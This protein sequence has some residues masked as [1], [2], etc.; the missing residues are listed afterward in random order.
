VKHDAPN[1]ATKISRI[2][3]DIFVPENQQSDVLTLRFAMH[4][5]P[6]RLGDPTMAAFDV[7]A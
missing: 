1:T 7:L 2:R 5:G 6:I 3:S 4:A